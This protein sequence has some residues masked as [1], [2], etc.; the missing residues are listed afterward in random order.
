M[1]EL[2]RKNIYIK[3]WILTLV[4]L[5]LH[6]FNASATHIR[7]GEITARRVNDLTLTYEFTFTGFRDSG[8]VIEFGAGV[9]DFGDG[10]SIEADFQIVKTPVG[11]EIEMVQFKVTHTYQAANSY[12]VSYKEEY[13]NEGIVNMDNS[14][15]TTFYVESLVVIDPF[16][17][18]NNTPILTVPPIDFAAVGSVFI[19]NPG[20][21]DEDGDSLSYKFTTPKQARNSVVNNYRRLVD[22]EFYSNFSQGNQ[23][24]N[25]RPELSIDPITGDLI[26]DA[27]GD[28]LNQ[29]ECSEYNV[30]FVVE[31]W[32]FIPGL[33]RWERLGFV[34]R[35]M[36]IIVCKSDNERPTLNVPD[37]VCVEAG[38][39]VELLI[40]GNDPDGDRVKLEAYGGPF[41]LDVPATYRPNPAE[42][43]GPPGYLTFSW[44]TECGHVRARPYQ[45]QFK[46]TD[47]PEEGPRL[48]EFE[49]L[50]IT[51]VGPAPTGLT[52]TVQPGR[53]MQLNWNNY[54][55]P[56]ADSIQIWR[57]VGEFDIEVDECQVGMPGNAGYSLID[58]VPL[59]QVEYLDNNNGRGL[60]PGAKYC[61]RLVAEYGSPGGGLSYVSAEACDSLNVTAPVIT[62]V[63][64]RT[65]DEEAGS[66]LVR[67]TPPYQIDEVLFP[68]DYTYDLVR[69]VGNGSFEVVVSDYTDT[70]YTDTGLNT[71]ARVHNYYVR[72]FDANGAI[73]DS[74]A[75]ASTPDRKSV[76]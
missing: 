42:Y 19:H 63:D 50:E 11:N 39:N 55:C 74:S 26:W 28:F 40:E 24:Q 44:D 41:E 7:A 47:D 36:Q 54:Q 49:T 12:I 56:N 15:N 46:V 21:F 16:Y 43:S 73:V 10:N 29:G 9:F 13:R 27:P 25:D 8:S 64:V 38:N 34:T 20:A 17:G 37:D 71:F 33:D 48:V 3:S 2:I 51:V 76:V 66:V 61:Y 60:A 59:G 58:K 72:A 65:T 31:E 5:L 18:K 22:P 4:V 52:T 14:V 67:W 69:S 30:A 57:R 70:V 62:N 68:P 1:K 53:A 32:R 45:V 23:D 35:D 75:I 6:T